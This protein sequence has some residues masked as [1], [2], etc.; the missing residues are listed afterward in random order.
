[1]QSLTERQWQ[2]YF[3]LADKL[4]QLPPAERR[5]ALPAL[6]AEADDG[7]VAAL[8][9]LRLGLRPE[10]DRCRS[11]ERI[12]NLV[13][14]ERIGSGGMGAVYRARQTFANGIEREVAV[15]LI[16]PTLLLQEAQEAQ[17]RFL[18]E[19]GTLAK[20]EHKG[21]ARI[22]DAGVAH[23]TQP[24]DATLYFAMELVHG[25]PLTEHV[26]AQ[27]GVLGTTGIVRL[28]LRV[29]DA[30]AYAHRHGIVHLDLKPANILV[31]R[32]GEPRVL[33]FGVA[34]SVSP[35][36]TASAQP[37]CTMAGTPAYMSPEQRAG[38]PATPAMDVY[39]L[40]VILRELLMN[41]HP[42]ARRGGSAALPTPAP[43]PA[44][45]DAAARLQ[46]AC[47]PELAGIVAHALAE[48]AAERYPSVADLA[49]ALTRR[50][51]VIDAQ[52]HAL[53]QA[54]RHLIGK[55]QAFWI[56]GVLE[57]SMAAAPPIEP[58]LALDPDAVGQTWTA[59]LQA[60]PRPL[61][62]LAPGTR[63]DD[64]FDRS[65]EALLILGV[66]GA[67]KTTL[68]LQ[69]ADALLARALHDA[70]ARVA[71]LLHLS[72]WAE[73]R[74]PLDDWLVRELDTRYDVPRA[75]GRRCIDGEQL[76]LLLDGLDEVASAQR[77]QCVA[78]INAFRREHES[79]PLAVCCRQADYEALPVRLRL[80][81]A[82]IVRTLTR[83]QV[84]AALARG[85]AALAGLR[86]V[87]SDNDPLRE[88]LSTP[89]LLGI[90]A[91]AYRRDHPLPAVGTLDEQ[92][93]QLFAA[94]VQAMVTRRGPLER[95]SAQQT[96][97]WL[98]W[99]AAAMLRHHQSVF[100]LES[101]Q[102]DWLARPIE[103]WAV[104]A[105]SIALCGLLIGLVV[106][107]GSGLGGDL[108]Y[109]LS[110][111]L[112][113]GLGGGMVV[114]MFGWGDRI[115]PITGLRWSLSSLRRELRA[116]LALAVGVGLLLFGG[117]SLVFDR[118]VAAA[119]GTFAALGFGYFAGLDP[120]LLQREPESITA[121]NQGI[122]QSMRNAWRGTAIGAAVGALA[123]G[124]IGGWPGLLFCAA[125]CSLV[126]AMIAGAH[127][128]LQHL[129]LRALLWRH[130]CTP[131]DFVSFLEFAVE[132]IFLRRVGGGYAFVH[133]ELQEYFARLHEVRC[134]P[135]EGQDSP[136][137]SAARSSP[138]P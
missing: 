4:Q 5:A 102:P 62:E 7:E 8:V 116:K 132:R 124:V 35:A 1:M 64:L 18:A 11:G 52:W 87:L 103:R 94:Y 114:G 20:L 96:T 91:L 49:H 38:A 69:L 34:A 88:L 65:R 16:H 83:A 118:T 99:L 92:R 80:A 50:L 74:L 15:K 117:V 22:Y 53:R 25:R 101:M 56:D 125:V 109:R 133:R 6:R 10:P 23:A 130:G 82:L 58:R 85:G 78:A 29:C 63:I 71:V 106:G 51:G 3:D 126:M 137:T 115:R 40:G 72:T 46:A 70:G 48:R 31:D 90:A 123:G 24:D 110:V 104:G 60:P 37:A 77:A 97:H 98:G 9:E 26:A 43:G 105:G 127:A 41:R 107:L 122:R 119:L 84:D 61:R 57:N 21:I 128:C 2:L 28:F 30:L 36:P 47:G 79:T 12:R 86:Q 75:I 19:I 95:Y 135:S 27:R 81:E 45:P 108:G 67:G 138:H 13:L 68:L 14:A 136:S 73:D 134:G 111:S 33:D 121:P 113:M 66:P 93:H 76:V 32:H 44:P 39:A 17:Q 59:V 129:M 89:L 42:A 100:Y 120:D 112:L 55:V 131:R 54:R